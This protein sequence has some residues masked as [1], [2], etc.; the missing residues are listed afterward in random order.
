MIH[1][2]HKE[3]ECA[4]E[5]TAKNNITGNS[6]GGSDG[7]GADIPIQRYSSNTISV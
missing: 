4:T 3:R 2:S 6:D 7:T 5:N 1:E